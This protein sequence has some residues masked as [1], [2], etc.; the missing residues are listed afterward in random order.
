MRDGKTKKIDFSRKRIAA[1][2]DKYYNEGEFISALRFAYKEMTMY[3]VDPDVCIRFADI[4]E[5][6]GLQG[7]A[8]NWLFRCL[9][10][11]AEE[12]F[13][14]I[15]EGLAVNFLS[16][17]DENQSA[18]Y[19]NKLIDADDTLPDETKL[20]I[21]DAF[22]AEKKDKF[23]FV[24][25]PRLADYSKEVKRGSIALKAGDCKG[26]IAEFSKVEKGSKEYLSAKEM[27]A[28]SHLLGGETDKAENLCTELLK[29]YPDELRLQATLA[30]V[31][32]EKGETE[33]SKEIAI[34]L[35]K[36]EVSTEDD[37]YK[38]A[39]VCC[40]NGLHEEA[41]EK[42]RQLKKFM[43]YDGRILYF[44]AVAAYKS[45]KIDEAVQA[46]DVLCAIYPDAEVAKY[47][48]RAIKNAKEGEGEMP[49]ML[50]FYHLPQQERES[51]CQSLIAIGKYPREEAQLFGLL[52]LHDGY[53]RWCFDEM[54]GADHDLQYLALITAE[55]VRADE[56]LQEVLLD[57]EV[58]DV[59]KIE[60]LRMLLERNE[61]MEL[62]IVLCNI[63]REIYL[64]CIKIGRKRHKKFI[65]A[66]AKVASKFIVINDKYADLLK[67]AAETLYGAVA[68]EDAFA[69][70]D[71]VDDCACAI[72]LLAGL[73]ELGREM[74]TVAAAFDADVMKVQALLSCVVN[75]EK[76]QNEERKDEID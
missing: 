75:K 36:R 43:P 18:Y 68:E 50:Y 4:Y 19:Y 11:S 20:E 22:S 13:P 52:A 64:P 47:F 41:Y 1:L 25:P 23:R 71:G 32:L 53:F 42:F 48:L 9:D 51:R 62:G 38:V 3:G 46:L 24:Y 21:V 67:W 34:S 8:I 29:E 27:Q 49:E 66:F 58:K 55:H 14:D 17:G 26:A 61:E 56:F 31:Y 37:I 69:L 63:Y 57:F 45:G 59:L 76:A 54:D 35:S 28:V 33:K 30:A 72:F 15:Y 10:I 6:M 65:Q 60:T 5:A 39:T 16:L 40:E 44:T 73:K 70:L 2:A 74:G 7:S 12:D